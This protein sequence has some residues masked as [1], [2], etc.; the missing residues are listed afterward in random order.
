ME[1]KYLLDIFSTVPG[2]HIT[3]ESWE[4]LYN[5]KINDEKV[6]ETF[7]LDKEKWE[8]LFYNDFTWEKF[9]ETFS[10]HEDDF[11]ASVNGGDGI[12]DRKVKNPVKHFDTN[13]AWFKHL[14]ILNPNKIL[15]IRI[16]NENPLNS[17]R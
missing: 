11:T 5:G 12:L 6:I 4:G 16:K 14:D 1:Y 13:K 10:L 2:I 8:D 9:I 3:E 17:I 15:T 7:S